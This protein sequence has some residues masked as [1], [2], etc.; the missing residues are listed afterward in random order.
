MRKTK[1]EKIKEQQKKARNKDIIWSV[2]HILEYD[3]E[4]VVE[5]LKDVIYDLHYCRSISPGTINK[6]LDP[7][8]K[9]I[10]TT[11]NNEVTNNE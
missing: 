6:H 7:W 9:L 4:K 3:S 8:Y 11:P 5:I 10:K 1:F 2:K